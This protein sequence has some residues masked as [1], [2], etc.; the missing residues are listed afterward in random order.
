MKLLNTIWYEKRIIS[1]SLLPFAWLYQLIIAIRRFTYQKKIFKST[2]F[3]L[4]IIVI[5]NITVGGTGKTPLVIY[6]ANWLKQQGYRPGIVSRG[7]GGKAQQ[8]PAKVTPQCKPNEVGD[9]PILIAKRTQCPVYVA[10]DR[11]A[12]VA[13]L[14]QENNCNVIISDDGLQ[15]YALARDVEIAVIDGDRRLG[16]GWCLPAGPLREPDKRLTEVDFIICNGQAQINEY[17][18]QLIAQ[19]F[20]Q[21][22][23]IKN[24]QTLEYFK[25]KTIHAVAGIG[26]PTRF[27]NSL[28]QLGLTIIE[29]PFPDHYLFEVDDFKFAGNDIIVMTEKD[30][31]KCQV[32]ANEN[33]WF[34]PVNASVTAEFTGKLLEKI[35]HID[36]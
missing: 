20:Y 5:G 8:Y 2:K 7:Y 17:P 12:A 33:Y 29:H 36:N 1:Y 9:E 27:F 19:D 28:R 34:L 15:H 30:A 3:P 35:A 22:C 14:L 16:N 6:L 21:V 31:V 13:K 25:N 18:M 11:V 23:N 24:K 26:N 10:P 32:F 4:P